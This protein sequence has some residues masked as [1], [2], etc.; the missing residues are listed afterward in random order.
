VPLVLLWAAAAADLLQ[1]PSG[2]RLALVLGATWR[3]CSPLIVV[4]SIGPMIAALWALKGLAPTRLAL[5]GAAAGAL[6]GAEAAFVYALHCTEM[7]APFL[8]VWYVTGMALPA[9]AGA[10]LGRRLLRW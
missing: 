5:A 10:L 2:E 1:A 4:L 9:L 8:A 3:A 7:Q 6:A